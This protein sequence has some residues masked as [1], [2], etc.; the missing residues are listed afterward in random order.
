MTSAT[1]A[2]GDSA[3]H[4]RLSAAAEAR[5]TASDTSSPIHAVDSV[6]TPVMSS[7]PAVR[8]FCASIRRSMMR[9]AAIAT[10]RPDT[11]AT[12]M[13]PRV[14]QWMVGFMAVRAAR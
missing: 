11:I 2:S 14:P 8:G 5:N 10:V 4:S 1:T 3:R 9:L 7:R 12:V 13:S 6:T